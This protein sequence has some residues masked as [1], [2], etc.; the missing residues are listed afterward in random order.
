MSTNR[1][2]LPEG[3]LNRIISDAKRETGLEVVEIIEV[4]NGYLFKGKYGVVIGEV[5][6][7]PE[8]EK[9]RRI[10][11]NKNAVQEIAERDKEEA[12][13]VTVEAPRTTRRQQQYK[14]QKR[15]RLGVA[16][17]AGAMALLVSIGAIIVKTDALGRDKMPQYQQTNTVASANDLILNSWANYAI[18]E[19]MDGASNS[20][21][22]HVQSTASE[23]KNNYFNGLMMQYYD[24]IDQVDADL[25]VDIA[26]DLKNK[27][28]SEFRNQCYIFDEVLEHSYFSYATFDESPYADA[29]VYDSNGDVVVTGGMYGEC[30]D[31]YGNL[32]LA[33]D[34]STYEVY[35]K[36]VDV[37]NNDYTIANLPLDAVVYNG[38]TYVSESHLD[39]FV[40]KQVKTK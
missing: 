38:E 33:S 3:T 11:Y 40:E 32:L 22:N 23:L 8:I 24:Y 30:Y 27:Y 25:P 7:I 15:K 12:K 17:T 29:I 37:P 5:S 19:V 28:H 16:L 20:R 1:R 9:Y 10:N 34:S 14:L 31:S 18:G 21:Y 35:V 26:G 39:D 6:Y 2:P 13:K 4:E 36:A